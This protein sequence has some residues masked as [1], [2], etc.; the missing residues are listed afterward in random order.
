MA[1]DEWKNVQTTAAYS[2]NSSIEL[3]STITHIRLD[4]YNA[5]PEAHSFPFVL[6]TH[7]RTEGAAPARST[8]AI[9]CFLTIRP[10]PNARFVSLPIPDGLASAHC[11]SVYNRH[12]HQPLSREN[13]DTYPKLLLFFI[14]VHR[15]CLLSASSAEQHDSDPAIEK[16]RIGSST[17]ALVE[18]SRAA[19]RVP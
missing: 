16:G 8:A 13:T 2:S 11:S 19:H 7:T 12:T 14:N 3:T 5:D 15:H 6:D 1:L 9:A 10:N 17:C 18:Q 4:Q